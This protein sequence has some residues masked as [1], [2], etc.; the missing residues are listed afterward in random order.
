MGFF[1]KKRNIANATQIDGR[2][3][4]IEAPWTKWGLKKAVTDGYSVSGWVY[5]AVGIIARSAATVKLQ[6]VDSND[7][8]I[9]NHPVSVLLSEPHQ[10]WSLYDLLELVF[11][12]QQL[13]GNAYL[14]RITDSNN[15]TL[16]IIPVSP[17]R[18]NPI[19][20]N[21][22][23]S[24]VAGYSVTSETGK[25]KKSNI[26]TP[27]NIAHF[28]LLDPANPLV[29][30][31]PLQVAAKSVDTDISQ[32]SWNRKAMHNK[33]IVDAVFTFEKQLNSKAYDTIKAKLTEMLTGSVNAHGVGVIG[34]N[35]KFQRLSLTPVEM[36][37]LNSRNMNMKEI[38]IIFG[39]PL[40]LAGAAET[41]SYNNFS[42][43]LRV[44]W[45]ITNMPLIQDFCDTLN[46]FLVDDL[47]GAKIK[48]DYSGIGALKQNMKQNIENAKLLHDM[49]VPVSE[50]NTRFNL[51]L[52]SYIGW[53][54]SHVKAATKK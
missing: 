29:G 44:L 24:L 16:A 1:R 42:E 41:M 53:N 52:D 34:S 17:D 48:P 2:I 36:D 46:R 22:N 30:I 32:Q 35:A 3:S 43:S 10:A 6:V 7:K 45:E 9:E 11:T 37:F 47:A 18:L 8:V 13:A 12:W 5:R 31:S 25:V 14:H 20:S 19:P 54:E 28:K 40:P 26:Y 38:F 27:S 23:D 49:G 33:G 39:I 15:R 4:A 51:G 50:L 21:N